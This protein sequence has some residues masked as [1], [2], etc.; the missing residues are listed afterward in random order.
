MHASF[1]SA[2]VLALGVLCVGSAFAQEPKRGGSL[3]FAVVAEPPNYDCHAST[4]FALLHPI[5]PH[6]ST[7]LKFDGANYP[8]IR[9]DLARSWEASPDGRTYTFR[10]H[11]NVRFHDGSRLTAED[12]KASYERIWQPPQGVVSARRSFWADLDRIDVTDQTT[13]VFR[14]KTAVAG[15]LEHFANPYNCIY[16]AKKLK[17]N[18][19][20]PETEIM[21]SGAFAFV[22]H[23][24]GSSWEGKRFDG[25]FVKDRPYLDGFKAYFVRSNA[26]V[27][28][29]LGGQFDAEFRGRN[30]KERDQLMADGG[31]RFVTNEGPWVGSLMLIFNTKKKP[32]DDVR[33]R[34]AISMAIDRWGGAEPLSKITILKGVGGVLRPGYSMALPESELIKLPGFAKNAESSRTI[35]RRYLAEAGISNLT[36]KLLNRNV[37]EPYTPAGIY[38]VD[39]LKRIGVTAQHEQL[40]TKLYFDAVTSG[41]FDVAVEF[42][43]DPNDDP[44]QQF[45]KYLTKA[46]S[47]LGYSGHEDAKLDQLYEQQRRAIDPVARRRI[48]NELERYAITTAYNVPL[49]WYHRIITNHRKIK[50]W[51]FT[52]SHYVQQDLVD[53]WLDQ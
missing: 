41:N 51:H 50:G 2:L 17:E 52:P 29:M 42:I 5:A 4:T 23:V 49:I 24:K 38:V 9:G 37:T 16:S 36:F 26:V 20:Y 7:L 27:P 21:G 48:V 30:P 28:G 6:Y 47:S 31:G 1:K 11:D 40:E 43:N 12:I 13:V 25:Y 34:Q 18:P 14:F 19:R 33:V 39:Q 46:S 15:I 44:T 22:Q 53:V 10:L 45:A 32:F 35:A 8:R 3:G